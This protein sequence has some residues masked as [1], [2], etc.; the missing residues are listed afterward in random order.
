MVVLFVQ[1]T[2]CLIRSDPNCS[3]AA[4]SQYS[5]KM[6]LSKKY[7]LVLRII[8]KNILIVTI[9]LNPLKF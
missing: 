3:I 9:H 4:F 2:I 8:I 5:K 7:E 6:N 1:I